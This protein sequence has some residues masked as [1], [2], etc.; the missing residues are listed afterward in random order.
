MYYI[1]VTAKNEMMSYKGWIFVNEK[2]TKTEALQELSKVQ[3]ALEYAKSDRVA[4]VI[5]MKDWRK[6]LWGA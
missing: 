4:R 6:E 1:Q 5:S 2:K 3:E